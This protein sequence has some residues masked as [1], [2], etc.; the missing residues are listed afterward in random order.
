MNKAQKLLD[1]CE[2]KQSLL[3]KI[4]KE[5]KEAFHQKKPRT[6]NPYKSSPAKEAWLDSWDLEH[7]QEQMGSW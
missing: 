3:D 7:D 6:A 5:G 2:G 4:A 1:V